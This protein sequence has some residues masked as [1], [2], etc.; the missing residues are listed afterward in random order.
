MLFVREQIVGLYYLLVGVLILFIFPFIISGGGAD[1]SLIVGH[2]IDTLLHDS[3]FIAP[4]PG[5]IRGNRNRAIT[6]RKVE[7]PKI[8]DLNR[9]DSSE[10]VELR[11]IGAYYASKIVQ[12]RERL[13]GFFDIRQLNELNLKYFNIDSSGFQ[14]TADQR[15]I[16]K[17]FIGDYEFKS[18]LRHPYLDYETLVLIFD[19]KREMAKGDTLTIKKLSAAGILRSTQAKKLSFYFY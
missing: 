17:R 19:Y 15:Y 10:L 3:L 9:A 12:Y 11:G 6:I 7:P 4:L 2:Q 16:V 13:G 14:I 1:G 8:I 5:E 18:L